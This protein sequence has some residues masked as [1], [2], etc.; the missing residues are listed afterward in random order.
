MASIPSRAKAER[1][2]ARNHDRIGIFSDRER[3]RTNNKTC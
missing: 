2:D 3:F 1:N